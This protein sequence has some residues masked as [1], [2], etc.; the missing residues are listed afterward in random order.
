MIQFLMKGKNNMG[1]E[2]LNINKSFNGK[3]VL[4]NTCF[5]M[6]IPG[7]FGLLGSNGARENYSF[8]NYITAF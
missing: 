1:L 6:N 3:K 5:S 2:I 7:I 8:K 4:D